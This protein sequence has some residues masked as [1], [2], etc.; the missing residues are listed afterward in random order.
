[1]QMDCI[2]ESNETIFKQSL[3][4]WRRSVFQIKKQQTSAEQTTETIKEEWNKQ[5]VCR[6]STQDDSF[7]HCKANKTN[8]TVDTLPHLFFTGK[9]VL[10]TAWLHDL[11]AVQRLE[12]AV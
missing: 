4:L 12:T 9:S 6:L 1:M 3:F 5:S 10:Q 8:P 7:I 2:S 11:S